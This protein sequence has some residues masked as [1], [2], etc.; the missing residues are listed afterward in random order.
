LLLKCCFKIWFPPIVLVENLVKD[1]RDS[2][3][4][5]NKYSL[6]L[7]KQI[8]NNRKES[9]YES[10]SDIEITPLYSKTECALK[11]NQLE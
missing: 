3:E 10:I 8:T 11:V 7:P 2:R 6:S 1:L 4:N 9:I 5:N